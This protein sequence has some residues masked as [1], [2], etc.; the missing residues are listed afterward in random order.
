[1]LHRRHEQRPSQQALSHKS[2]PAALTELPGYFYWQTCLREVQIGDSRLVDPANSLVGEAASEKAASWE[3]AAWEL[4]RGYPAYRFLLELLLG[5]HSLI[6]GESE[7]LGQFCH[8]LRDQQLPPGPQ[9]AYLRSLRQQVRADARKMRAENLQGLGECS[10]GGLTRQLLK[11]CRNIYLIGSGYLAKRLLPWLKQEKRD[12]FVIGRRR[13]QLEQLERCYGISGLLPQEAYRLKNSGND[14]L[15]I[16]APLHSLENFGHLLRQQPTVLDF[17][18]TEQNSSPIYQQTG[19]YK[20]ERYSKKR[21]TK[22]RYYDLEQIFALADK[23][24]N[25]RRQLLQKLQ[26]LLDSVVEKRRRQGR[27][28]IFGWED[29]EFTLPAIYS[30]GQV[31]ST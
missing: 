19:V 1:M 13:E 20:A 31:Y 15:I 27:Q 29:I 25:Q 22:N 16:A 4:R 30:A 11:H 6:I 14:A 18:A 24:R 10:Y 26:P 5:L 9:G 7:V 8:A 28:M 3:A 12:I 17:R 21:Y 2:A 23:N